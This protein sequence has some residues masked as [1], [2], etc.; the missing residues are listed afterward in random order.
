MA[1]RRATQAAT[2]SRDRTQG[3]DQRVRGQL[4]NL[5]T[6]P[7]SRE[8]PAVLGKPQG[9]C[10]GQEPRKQIVGP[11][12]F[13]DPRLPRTPPC[14]Q[15]AQLRAGA[16]C[17]G[18]GPGGSF[19]HSCLWQMVEQEPPSNFR[20]EWETPRVGQEVPSSAECSLWGGRAQIPVLDR[21]SGQMGWGAREGATYHGAELHHQQVGCHLCA[22]GQAL[23][24]VAVLQGPVGA[25][26]LP[27]DSHTGRRGGG[28]WEEGGRH[29]PCLGLPSPSAQHSPHLPAQPVTHLLQ[30]H[31]CQVPPTCRAAPPPGI[32]P[33][34]AR[35]H[36]PSAPSPPPAC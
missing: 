21:S 35:W 10:Y 29:R 27:P 32:A 19:K 5:L 8:G 26:R 31:L 22:L 36:W 28:V 13:R 34:R 33:A 7:S 12:C 11:G 17:A 20:G 3:G 18:R 14:G 24:Q 2:P 23:K 9:Q 30:P 25:N 6:L 4:P 15:A 16:V 1:S